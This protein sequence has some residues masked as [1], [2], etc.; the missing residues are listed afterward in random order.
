M[1]EQFYQE[2]IEDGHLA[3]NQVQCLSDLSISDTQVTAKINFSAIA[4][5]PMH[6]F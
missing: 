6:V 3:R 5:I 4:D 2:P 1:I